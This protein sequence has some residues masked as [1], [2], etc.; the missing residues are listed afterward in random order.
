MNIIAKISLQTPEGTVQPGETL[1][2]DDAEARALIARGFA[3]LAGK[4]TAAKT[5]ETK[6]MILML[7]FWQSLMPS[8]FWMKAALAR[9]ASPW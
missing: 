5:P 3:E 6:P 8:Q 9:M 7:I 1:K 4:S 2:L